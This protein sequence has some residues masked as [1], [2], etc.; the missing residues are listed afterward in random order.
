MAI[1]IKR[2]KTG[3]FIHST[4]DSTTTKTLV[5][6]QIGYE[7]AAS[8]LVFNDGGTIKKFSDDTTLP[9]VLGIPGINNKIT[10]LETRA[11]AL[12]TD[13]GTAKATLSSLVTL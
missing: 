2:A 13:L 6:R 10:D 12:E 9:T 3:T 1:K 7:K 8:A 5:D 11:T 4:T